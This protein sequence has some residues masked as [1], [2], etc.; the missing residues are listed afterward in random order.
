MIDAGLIPMI[1]TQLTKGEFQTQKEAAWAISNLTISGSKQQVC[2]IVVNITVYI[3]FAVASDHI[4]CSNFFFF[5]LVTIHK[6]YPAVLMV[7]NRN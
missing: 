3:C 4:S 6:Q 2:S 5:L 7:N 1:I